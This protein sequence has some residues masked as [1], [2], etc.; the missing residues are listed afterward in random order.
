VHHEAAHHL[1]FLEQRHSNYRANTAL[2]RRQLSRS[3]GAV[4][5]ILAKVRHMHDR[6]ASQHTKWQG[7][8]GIQITERRIQR[9]QSVETFRYSM[10]RNA[11]EISILVAQ[12]VASF[13][14]AKPS[15][16]LQHRVEDRREVA[17]RRIN[18][19]QDFSARFLSRGRFGKFGLTLG[20][21]ALQFRNLG[22]T[23]GDPA[24]QLRNLAL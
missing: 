7:F 14:P 5:F 23:L 24:L 21:P 9:D 4:R 17:G 2:H 16:F 3:A 20:E 11:A 6:P 10:T 15:G 1:P 19:L 18:D 13:R 8:F 22:V 12:Q